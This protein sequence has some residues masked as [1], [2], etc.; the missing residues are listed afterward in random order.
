LLLGF[1]LQ[2]DVRANNIITSFGEGTDVVLDAVGKAAGFSEDLERGD[3]RTSD[4]EREGWGDVGE[5][6]R[7]AS[8]WFARRACSRESETIRY[9]MLFINAIDQSFESGAKFQTPCVAYDPN[10]SLMRESNLTGRGYLYIPSLQL[11][12]PSFRPHLDQI[13]FFVLAFLLCY[14][15]CS[16]KHQAIILHRD[17]TRPSSLGLQHPLFPSSSSPLRPMVPVSIP[18]LQGRRVVVS[19]C[20]CHQSPR[21]V[22]YTLCNP[23]RLFLLHQHQRIRPQ[24][25]SICLETVGFGF[26]GGVFRFLYGQP[27]S[28]ERRRISL[29]LRV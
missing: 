10:L 15:R 6:G 13:M 29:K 24:R 14:D 16:L 4:V 12:P 25:C 28:K 20:S 17:H 19:G 11:P 27:K 7:H 9:R 1:L 21:P 5:D 22:P 2:V 23:P 3:R 18:N 8:W 26:R